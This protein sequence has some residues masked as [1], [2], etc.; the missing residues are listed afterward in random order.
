LPNPVT[1]FFVF[2]VCFPCFLRPDTLSPRFPAGYPP[3]FSRCSALK[4]HFFSARYPFL[5]LFSPRRS[6]SSRCP[7]VDFLKLFVLNLRYEASNRNVSVFACEVLF[8]IATPI[9]PPR[10][11]SSLVDQCPFLGI[12]FPSVAIS[13][14]FL[15]VLAALLFIVPAGCLFHRRQRPSAVLVFHHFLRPLVFI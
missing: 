6:L 8:L 12:L 4:G 13:F 3:S 14:R 10:F 1:H 11:L 15:Q 2:F 5:C 7:D 9:L